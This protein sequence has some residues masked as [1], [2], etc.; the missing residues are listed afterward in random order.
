[1]RALGE[2]EQRARAL[3]AQAPDA[4]FILDGERPHVGR[5]S[6][7]IRPPRTSRHS[8]GRA[9]GATSLDFDAE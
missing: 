6:P 9:R 5:V 2:S 1:M 8:P 3:F 4:I 7:P